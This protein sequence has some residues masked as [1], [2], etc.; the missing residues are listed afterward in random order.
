MRFTFPN[1]G[2]RIALSRTHFCCPRGPG[3]GPLDLPCARPIKWL[4]RHCR[5]Q[6]IFLELN[7]SLCC[8]LLK[9]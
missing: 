3:R 2:G 5:E 7:M 4:I 6:I 8:E 9:L 1:A